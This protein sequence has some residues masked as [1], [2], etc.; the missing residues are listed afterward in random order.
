M[1]FFNLLLLPVALFIYFAVSGQKKFITVAATGFFVGMIVCGVRFVFFFSHRLVPESFILNYL[2]YVTRLVILP[3]IV[4]VVFVLISKDSGE[5]KIKSF[6][7]L[8][9]SFAIVYYP[10][11]FL[12]MSGSVYNGYDLFFRPVIYLSMLTGFALSLKRIYSACVNEEPSS[13]I[14]SIVIAALI[15]LFPAVVD[16]SYVMNRFFWLF[17]ILGIVYSAGIIGFSVISYFKKDNQ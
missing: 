12:T 16:T 2:F 5:F 17:T 7:P 6:F 4:Y 14:N 15:L 3:M 8:M 10:Y 9:T 11:Y 13:K 1:I